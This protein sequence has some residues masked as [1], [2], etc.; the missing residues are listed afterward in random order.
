MHGANIG[1]C[2]MPILGFSTMLKSYCEDSFSTTR[3]TL[4]IDQKQLKQIEQEIFTVNY[5]SVKMQSN[6]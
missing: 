5:Q 1:K 4:K 6:R 3:T 2:I